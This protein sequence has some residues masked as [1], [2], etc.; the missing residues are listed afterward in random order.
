MSKFVVDDKQILDLFKD[1]SPKKQKTAHK[2][3]LKKSANILVRQ[4]KRNLQEVTDKAKSKATNIKN[5]WNFKKHKSGKVTFKSLQDGI[6]ASVAQ[7]AESAKVHIMGDFRLKWFELGTK[8]RYTKKGYYR[9][10][11]QPTYFFKKAK[12]STE[13]EISETLQENLRQ[14]ILR[15]AK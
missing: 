8:E 7:D 14:S 13:S 2:N 15:A 9:G 11:M 10:R 3:A 12:E 5:N 1:L 4:A 6:K